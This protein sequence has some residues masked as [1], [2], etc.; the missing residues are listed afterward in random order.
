MQSFAAAQ[1]DLVP[2]AEAWEG[3]EDDAD[4]PA[5][6][7]FP[8]PPEPYYDTREERPRVGRQKRMLVLH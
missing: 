2:N 7:P 3:E 6:E 5:L 4:I 1:D 8:D